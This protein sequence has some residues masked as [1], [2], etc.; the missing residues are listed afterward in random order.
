MN[1]LFYLVPGFFI[2]GVLNAKISY[3][4]IQ[5]IDVVP[6]SLKSYLGEVDPPKTQPWQ[7][8]HKPLGL[9]KI[10]FEKETSKH[11]TPTFETPTV[12]SNGVIFTKGELITCIYD[13][14]MS[15]S[16]G[17][18]FIK[19][20]PMQC[21]V[22]EASEIL[23]DIEPNYQ[24][25]HVDCTKDLGTKWTTK[26]GVGLVKNHRLNYKKPWFTSNDCYHF[27]SN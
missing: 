12:K 20:I 15:W 6:T 1:K 23:D 10:V 8:E 14:V 21:E 2:L 18:E 17:E 9:D 27:V 16:D 13:A 22:I 4:A 11:E 3:S 24:H 5:N 25:I 19:P 26:P 7:I